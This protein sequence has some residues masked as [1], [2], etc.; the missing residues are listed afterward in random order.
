M[1][2]P[3]PGASLP[4]QAKHVYHRLVVSHVVSR[5]CDAG[6]PEGVTA[7]P[8][9]YHRFQ[10]TTPNGRTW[11]FAWHSNIVD[12]LANSHIRANGW[13]NEF[14]GGIETLYSAL[15]LMDKITSYQLDTA[16]PYNSVTA[17]SSPI[18]VAAT[19][20]LGPLPSQIAVVVTL[21][22]PST[23]RKNRGRFYLPA[24]TVGTLTTTGEFATGSRDAF[25]AALDSA[26]STSNSGG[27][28]PGV[29]SKTTGI[30]QPYTEF[31]VGDKFDTQRKR[32]SAVVPDRNFQPMP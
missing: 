8:I 9:I 27:E 32:V 16:P 22:M 26:W 14:I 20:V 29:F 11:G 5:T 1:R 25:V 6:G 21:R 12:T 28:R 4:D 15:T 23:G 3:A 31:G 24:P 2:T 13:F 30:F 19:G 17:V 10:G 7:M 18:S